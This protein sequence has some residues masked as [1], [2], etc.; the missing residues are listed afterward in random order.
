MI[1]LGYDSEA[2]EF[3]V[4]DGLKLPASSSPTPT[5]C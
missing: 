2:D 5:A 3:G 1:E 4:H